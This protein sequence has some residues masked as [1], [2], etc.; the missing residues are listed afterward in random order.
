MTVTVSY[1]GRWEL[2]QKQRPKRGQPVPPWPGLVSTTTLARGKGGKGTLTITLLVP[3]NAEPEPSE[4]TQWSCQTVKV[5]RPLEAHPIFNGGK[6]GDI[7]GDVTIPINAS[8][9]LGTEG[10]KVL[11]KYFDEQHAKSTYASLIAIAK[12]DPE[13]KR[14]IYPLASGFEGFDQGL[15]N[16]FFAKYDAGIEAYEISLPIVRRTTTRNSLPALK[17]ASFRETPTMPGLPTRKGVKYQW[18]RDSESLTWNGQLA[19]FD[20]EWKGAESID[21]DIYP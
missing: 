11:R 10:M 4:P 17:G 18:L 12:Q 9:S 16:A 6:Y 8:A 1:V 2:C 3:P 19:T 21:T 7:K 13:F 5:E 20:E 14:L 15:V